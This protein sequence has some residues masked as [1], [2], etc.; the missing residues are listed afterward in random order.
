LLL[1]CSQ[2]KKCDEELLPAIDRY[3]G[4]AYRVLRLYL[5]Q[6]LSLPVDVRIL[7]A[8]YGLI[9]ASY[10]LPYYDCRITKEQSGKL[11]HQVITELETILNS[12]TY[13]NLLVCLG[14]DYIEAIYGYESIIPDRLTVQVA[15][16]GL[17]RKLS[18]LHNWLYGDS[19]NLR[20]RHDLVATTGA[21][22]LRGIEVNLTSEQVLDIARRAITTK[23]RGATH[24][25]SWYVQVDDQRVAPKW[26]VSQITGLPVS[27]FVTDDARRV[28]TRLGVEVK[29]V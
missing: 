29:R 20:N 12:K 2:R 27:N 7:S 9:P 17:G 15:T 16:G 19:S 26:L 14:R 21:V 23:D 25:Q 18:I 28:L 11:R 10:Y 3:D 13:T 22:R 24:C 4:S 8:K 1:S 5:K 6:G